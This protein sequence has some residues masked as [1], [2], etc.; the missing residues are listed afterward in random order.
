MEVILEQQHILPTM[1]MALEHIR[2][3]YF[4]MNFH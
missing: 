1:A 2:R 3:S 4:Q